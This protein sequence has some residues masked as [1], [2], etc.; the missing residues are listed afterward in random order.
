M[1]NK[2]SGVAMQKRPRTEK[3]STFHQFDTSVLLAVQRGLGQAPVVTGARTLSHFGEH[4]I[5]WLAIGAL[6]AAVDRPRR[7]RWLTGT[8]AVFAGHAAAVVVK[9]VVRRP[10]PHDPRVQVNVG[11]PS[12]LSMPS[13]HAT[14][15]A[16]AVV[17]YSQLLGFPGFA[18]ALPIM[19][20]SRLVLGVH[21]PSDVVSGAVLGVAVGRAVVAT[22]PRIDGAKK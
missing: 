22:T 2:D 6:G 19:A 11:T 21:Y 18:A 8:A 12:A 17:A 4:A 20:L 1:R 9:R 14:S 15:T 5:G 13:A 3:S 10:R 7:T 16:S